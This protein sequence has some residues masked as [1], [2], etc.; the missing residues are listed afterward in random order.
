MVF[1]AVHENSIRDT[2]CKIL[3]SKFNIENELLNSENDDIPL[4]GV[5]FRMTSV[6]LVYLFFEIEKTLDIKFNVNHLD[7]YGFNC[8]NNITRA[9]KTT[10]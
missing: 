6:E 7:D 8:I 5:V 4:T 10:I 3:H 1:M 9:I 2:V